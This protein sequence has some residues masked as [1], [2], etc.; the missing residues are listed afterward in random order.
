M[1]TQKKRESLCPFLFLSFA[2]KREKESKLISEQD[3]KK[4]ERKK[5]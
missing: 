4:K 1:E 5:G 3:L 2:N